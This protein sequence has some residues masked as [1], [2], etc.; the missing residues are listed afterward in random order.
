MNMEP[1]SVIGDTGRPMCRGLT[2]AQ[3]KT[4]SVYTAY[5]DGAE[6]RVVANVVC[7]L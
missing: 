6:L 5:L 4:V 2:T 1:L 3:F 7:N